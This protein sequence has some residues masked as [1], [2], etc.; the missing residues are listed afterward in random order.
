M[1]QTLLR[2][3]VLANLAFGL[4]LVIGTLSYLLLPRQQDP[5]INFNWIIVTTVLP[6][7]AALDVEQKVTDPL[8][9]AI[10][11]VRNMKFVTSNSRESVSSLLVRFEDIDARTFDKRINDL[12]REIQN[13]ED[14]LPE[15]AEDP[16]ILEITS[17]NAFP[18]ATIAVVGRADD[19]NLRQQARNVEKDLERLSG[20]DRVDP[21]GLSDPELQVRFDPAALEALA[22]SPSQLADT[23]SGFFQD[24]AAGNL[25]LG[26]QD[27]LVRLV[28]SDSD[29]RSLATR[30]VVGAPGEVTLGDLARVQRLVAA[31]A[32]FRQDPP[33]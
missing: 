2:N 27:W 12:R 4:V 21:I 26:S 11:N 3:H 5:T 17:A 19:E 24:I 10:R 30:P 28:G 18:S 20:V 16:E 15:Q 29:P 8:E 31:V 6:G 13:A 1:L 25:R 23:V 33:S 7:A 22:L 32:A 9:D 14:E